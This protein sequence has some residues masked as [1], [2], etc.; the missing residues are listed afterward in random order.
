MLV[1]TCLLLAANRL[2]H[3]QNCFASLRCTSVDDRKHM[4][5]A[6]HLTTNTYYEH[7]YAAN[8]CE[9]ELK[10]SDFLLTLFV[11]HLM[12]TKGS[13]KRPC[14]EF[15]EQTPTQ[16]DLAQQHL[17]IKYRSQIDAGNHSIEYDN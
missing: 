16:I 10:A 9:L 7:N 14:I 2:F 6:H 13:T 17:V 8:H 4:H 12:T 11:H 3:D 15:C 5:A 1:L